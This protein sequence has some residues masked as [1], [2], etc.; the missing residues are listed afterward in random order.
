MQQGP[1]AEVPAL[2]RRVG[3]NH[4]PSG[5]EPDELP[6]LYFAMWTAKLRG[7]RFTAKKNGILFGGRA[8]NGQKIAEVAAQ[9]AKIA[10]GWPCEAKIPNPAVH[11]TDVVTLFPEVVFL[12]RHEKTNSCSVS[13]RTVNDKDVC[14]TRTT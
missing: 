12:L 4:R 8:C 2:L 5:Y 10:G 14:T 7:I 13:Q 11:F 6:L 9:H 3:S 1:H